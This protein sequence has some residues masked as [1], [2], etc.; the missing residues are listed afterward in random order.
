[1]PV[2]AQ[3]SGT[4]RGVCRGPSAA[5]PSSRVG[6][7]RLLRLLVLP[8]GGSS[9]WAPRAAER[10]VAYFSLLSLKNPCPAMLGME[11]LMNEKESCLQRRLSPK[12]AHPMETWAWGE[13]LL[14]APPQSTLQPSDRRSL[15]C[16]TPLCPLPLTRGGS[17]LLLHLHL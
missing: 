10:S 12:G 6:V 13:G 5:G 14:P 2:L 1:M 7:S 4:L 8:S 9:A 15:L 3:G 11:E 17:S 16:D